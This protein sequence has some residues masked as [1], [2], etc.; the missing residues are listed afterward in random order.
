M[1][2]KKK[3]PGFYLGFVTVLSPWGSS[4]LFRERGSLRDTSDEDTTFNQNPPSPPTLAF[5]SNL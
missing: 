1:R 2:I 4:R 5:E 3:T